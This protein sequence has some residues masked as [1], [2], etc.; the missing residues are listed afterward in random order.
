MRGFFYG[1]IMGVSEQS[2]PPWLAA[3]GQLKVDHLPKVVDLVISVRLSLEFNHKS[4]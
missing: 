3:S 4:C 2:D 1:I